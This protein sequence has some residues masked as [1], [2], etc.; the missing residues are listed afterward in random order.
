MLPSGTAYYVDA[1]GLLY[2]HTVGV[3]ASTW[4]EVAS[5]PYHGAVTVFVSDGK[6]AYLLD[7]Y[8]NLFAIDNA[9][10]HT[11]LDNGG[12]GG[13]RGFAMLPSG[14]AYYVDAGGLLYSHSRSEERRVG[15]ECRSG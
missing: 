12:A 7:T 14:T 1:G 13:V 3:D 2:L 15:K 10:F 11:I 4:T 8:H 6:A 9:G 5:S